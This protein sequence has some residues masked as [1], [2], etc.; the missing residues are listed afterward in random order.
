MRITIGRGVTVLGVI[1]AVA[2][3]VW[4]VVP[5]PIPVETATATKGRFVASV[6]EDGKTRVRERYVVAAPLAGRLTR[7]RLKA[8]DRVEADDS[9]ATIAPSPAPFLDPRSRRE[10]EE[11]L[12]AAEA[13]LERTKAA[14]ERA[15]AQ[16]AQAKTDLDR[17][18]TLVERGA[19]TT[20]AL[21]RAELAMRVADRDL[22]AADF[23]HHAAEHE[24]DQARALLARYQDGANS[25]SDAWNVRAPV[26]GVVLKVTQE[27]ETIVQP[28]FPLAEIGDPRDLEIVVDVLS[29]NAVGIRPGAEVV[30]EHW[31]GQG[32][33]SGCVRRVEPAAFTKVSTLGVEEQR[34][35]VLVDISSPPEQWV[36]LGDAFQVDTR[37]TVFTQE[38]ATIVPT[39]ALFRRGE[40]WNVYVVDNGR[41]Q[42]REIKLLR[43]S[44][45]FAAVATGLAP[46]ERV[47]VF[48]SDRV[49]NGAW[50]E[51]R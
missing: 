11:R 42:V 24:L 33:L 10:A 41:A 3:I 35:N 28:G 29:T 4:S 45:R 50:V 36:G 23:L 18:R 12:G 17:T 21:E 2:G 9:I 34:V 20:Q 51:A 38:D 8:G 6:D 16:T 22:R 47:I 49:A 37:I 26:P 13:T 44:G 25:A 46:G 39:G 1:L 43:R 27:S 14:V 30:I 5:R 7:I 19:S 40:I 48:P 15:Q 31:G 32:I